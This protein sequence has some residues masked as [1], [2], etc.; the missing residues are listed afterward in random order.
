M[1]HSESETLV[2]G[3]LGA[4]LDFHP[5]P[6]DFRAEVL[7]GLG[8]SPKSIP[9]MFLY[10]QRGSELFDDICALDEYYLTRT[11]IAILQACA[12]EMAGAIGPQAVLVEL[13]SGSSTKTPLLL[14]ELEDPVAYV[15]VDISRDHLEASSHAFADRFPHLPVLPV[16]ADFNEPFDL[17]AFPRRPRRKAA[18]FSGSTIGNLEPDGAVALLR[19]IAELVGAGG[20]ALIATDLK[21]DP[22]VLTAAYDDREGVTAEFELNLL[23]RIND[24]LDADF[25]PDR[26][27]HHAVWDEDHG[28]IEISLRSTAAQ[29]VR[30]GDR[31]FDFAA[32]ELLRTE[33]SHKFDHAGFAAL[34]ARA[35]MAV[36]Q[37]WNDA[38]DLFSI[39]LL[40][41]A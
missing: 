15:P 37:V 7:A 5:Q 19:T 36:E 14:A 29:T 28:R 21:K 2:A 11:E 20:L 25:D 39:Q 17:P 12:G 38:D 22:A 26:F 9:S 4:T 6:G 3:N 24:E 16:C 40:R 33:Y 32:G 18:F 30:V 8:G 23:R 13:G 1:T 31:S 34:A 27:R 10:D 35:G 41:S